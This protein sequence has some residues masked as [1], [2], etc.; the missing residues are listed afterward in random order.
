MPGSTADPS[1]AV[2]TACAEALNKV[3]LQ[4]PPEPTGAPSKTVNAWRLPAL[5]SQRML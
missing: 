2:A 4:K 3:V 5:A 1:R